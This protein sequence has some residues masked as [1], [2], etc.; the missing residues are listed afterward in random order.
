MFD[1]L[2]GRRDRGR[3]PMESGG[4][5][6]AAVARSLKAWRISLPSLP[7]TRPK[8]PMDSIPTYVE[9]AITRENIR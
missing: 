3:V 4:M 2:N 6:Q 5:T 1:M 9:T 8:G 7:Y